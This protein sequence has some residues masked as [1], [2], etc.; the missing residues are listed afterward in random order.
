[1]V[2]IYHHNTTNTYTWCTQHYKY[3]Y[4]VYPTLQI[5]IHGVPN[6]TNTYT[7]CTQH[8]KYIHMV[9]PTLQIHTHG[10]PNTT[11]TYTWCTQHYKYIQNIYL[12]L[13]THKKICILY[14]FHV[15]WIF[16]I[17]SLRNPPKLLESVSGILRQVGRKP[18][19]MEN[20]TK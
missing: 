2:G 15:R 9:Y 7:W 4:M 11:N 10:V 8:Y 20:H 5:H 16:L 12:H 1:M 19:H 18:S 13:R 6:T 17:T 14:G 3:I